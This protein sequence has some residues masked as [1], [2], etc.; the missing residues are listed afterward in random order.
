[1]KLVK[2]PSLV[3]SPMSPETNR[4]ILD[5]DIQNEDQRSQ[6]VEGYMCRVSK[7]GIKV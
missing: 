1:M 2:K 3:F 6:I 4:S 7:N 5:T